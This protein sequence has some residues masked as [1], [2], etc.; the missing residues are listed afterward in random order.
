MKLGRN[1]LYIRFQHFFFLI[2]IAETRNEKNREMLPTKESRK[3]AQKIA[4]T[5]L[6]QTRK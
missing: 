5:N 3:K 6:L 2:A 1:Y 4:L